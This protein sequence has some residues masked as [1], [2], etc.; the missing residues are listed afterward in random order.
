[1]IRLFRRS[2]I[3]RPRRSGQAL[4]EFALVFPIFLI[5]LLATIEFSF[6]FNAVLSANYATRDASLVG[7]EAGSNN[8]ADCVIIAKV[9]DDMT[10][11]VDA[12]RIS[13][14]IIYRANSS[15][16]PVSGSY[17]GS[18]NVWTHNIVSTTDCSAYGES[19]NLPFKLTTTNYP[20]GLPNLT[21]GA[22]GRCDYINGCPNNSLRSRDTIGVQVSYTYVWHT[23]LSNFVPLP[24][25][26]FTVVRANEMRMEP[27]L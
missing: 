21:T 18:G 5:L 22:G 13:Q 17:S 12:S 15:G 2:M 16:G 1:M 26:S 9:L 4:V 3:G 19:A 8:G 14:I 11:P 7:A 6:A 20:E 27:I 25:G 10:P 24:A 23:P